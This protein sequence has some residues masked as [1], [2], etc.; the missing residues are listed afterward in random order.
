MI[1]E[2]RTEPKIL[3]KKKPKVTKNP[4]RF[5][6]HGPPQNAIQKLKL[7]KIVDTSDLTLEKTKRFLKKI[8]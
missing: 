4:S 3:D 5:A 2:Y 7:C 1:Y 6:T 8:R